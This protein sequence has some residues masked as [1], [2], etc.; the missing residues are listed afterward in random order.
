MFAA[1]ESASR[2]RARC[3]KRGRSPPRSAAKLRA[4]CAP[5]T[6]PAR[7]R[8]RVE[9]EERF[10]PARLGEPI[11]QPDRLEAVTA[12]M[13]D[14]DLRQGAAPVGDCGTK[15]GARARWGGLGSLRFVMHGLDPCIH[16][17]RPRD[18][19]AAPW[20]TGTGAESGP[21]AACAFSQD[22][23][24]CLGLGGLSLQTHPH[25][26]AMSGHVSRPQTRSR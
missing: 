24:G 11:D 17:R 10:A 15:E 3:G 13:A 22:G 8:V 4:A 14:K 25:G 6:R 7:S 20:M 2:T 19:H 9:V 21:R 1:T 18:Y 16:G 23:A 5:S 26:L 12:G